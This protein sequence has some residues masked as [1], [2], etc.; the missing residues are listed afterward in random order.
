VIQ[1]PPQ[2][3]LLY[4][5]EPLAGVAPGARPPRVAESAAAEALLQKLR[6]RLPAG[7]SSKAH[8]RGLAAAAVST[9]GV[10]GIDLEYRQPGR[11]IGAIARWLMGQAAADDAAAYRVFTYREAFFKA[12]GDWPG[13]PLM[14]AVAEARTPEFRAPDG[15]RVRHENLG[16]AF[17][18]TLV[19]SSAA[20]ATR[21]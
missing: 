16:E 21:L 17:V 18:L 3:G 10:V 8:A 7:R 1:A 20:A 12:T 15:L 2:S 14:R 13:A 11:D 4:V 19:W 6:A 5:V 9:E